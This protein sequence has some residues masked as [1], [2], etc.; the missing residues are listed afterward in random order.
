M[1]ANM[2]IVGDVGVGVR[3]DQAVLQHIVRCEKTW[4][5][6]ASGVE[7]VWPCTI[8]VSGGSCTIIVSGV[9]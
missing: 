8:M 7:N 2:H 6:I 4:R 5:T 1:T 9:H 3:G